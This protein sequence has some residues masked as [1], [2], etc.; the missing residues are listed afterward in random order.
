MSTTRGTLL[1]LIAK[2]DIDKYLYQESENIEI[3]KS[4]FKSG[5]KKITNFSDSSV[6]LYPENS[7]SWGD[8][9]TFKIN[10]YGDLLSNMYL[11]FELPQI[12]VEDIV[13][14]SE[15]IAT[16]SYRIKWQDYIGNI[17][18]EKATLRIGGQK[19]DEQTGEFMQFHTDLY[20]TTWSKLCMIG[21][22]KNLI[23]PST[24]IDKQ[25]IY[26]PLKFFFCNDITKSLPI[27]ALNHHEVELEIKLRK[28]D[29]LYFVLKT[30]VDNISDSESKTSKIFY[31]HTT[32]TIEQKN[33]SG[34][35]L[36][37]N[38][39]FLDENER[40]YFINN[41]HEILI[42][43][44]QYQEQSCLNNQKI[45]LN[46]NN[47]IK[48]L[49]YVFQ[50]NTIENMGE[51]FNYSGKSKY[52]PSSISEFTET[53][54]I[55]IPHKHLL[56]KASMQFN[57]NDRVS[58]KDYKYWHLVQNYETYRNRLEHNIYTFSFGLNKNEHSGSCNFSELD[59]VSLTVKLSEATNEIY[60]RNGNTV[61]I[62]PGGSNKIK[63][64]AVN[65][66]IF[67]IDSGMGAVMFPY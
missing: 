49:I 27:Y 36:D 4:I 65:Y 51:I 58:E 16:S 32:D 17:A 28:W 37:C 9:V 18:I 67:K 47:P 50:S 40:N 30:M 45:F 46:F 3:E 15:S 10:K 62:G 31:H 7:P 20:D 52:L 59:D 38:Y 14:E 29:D 41:K 34:L 66:N 33:I 8:T 55:Q 53:L 24:K 54:W 21:H 26:V 1:Q 35:K 13:N 23:L 11:S 43:Q 25:Y 48:E 39:I 44:V 64:Y 5:I 12:S 60:H 56:D 61:S 63:V 22:E 42:Q 6:S 2:G 57:G 19:I